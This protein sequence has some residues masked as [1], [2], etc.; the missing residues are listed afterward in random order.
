MP[1][2]ADMPPAAPT[3][4]PAAQVQ[5]ISQ[6]PVDKAAE[7]ARAKL[8]ARL[9]RTPTQTSWTTPVTRLYAVQMSDGQVVFT[10]ES[11]RYLVI[12]V[13]M[14]LDTGKMLYGMGGVPA[15]KPQTEVR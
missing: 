10:D 11:A 4:A 14:D 7:A 5:T 12:G 13:M 9:P 3:Q 15:L 1:F 8:Q 2:V 6:T